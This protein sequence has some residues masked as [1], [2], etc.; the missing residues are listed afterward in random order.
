MKLNQMIVVLCLVG[1]PSGAWAHGNKVDSTQHVLETAL[2]KF[3]QE[4]SAASVEA[5]SG[6]KAWPDGSDIKVKIYLSANTSLQYTCMEHV[7]DGKEM[8]MC[9]KN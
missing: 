2:E 4:E 3:K 5:F 8:V 6:V 7:M 1:L 9:S